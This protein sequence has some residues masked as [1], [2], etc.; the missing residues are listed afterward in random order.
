M[1]GLGGPGIHATLKVSAAPP[2]S[3]THSCQLRLLRERCTRARWLLSGVSGDWIHG[4]CNAGGSISTKCNMSRYGD[5]CS[6]L[7]VG[8]TARSQWSPAIRRFANVVHAAAQLD[9]C[10]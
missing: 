7:A 5:W 8:M 4:R 3:P 6:R 2:L 9:R 10:S 1:F